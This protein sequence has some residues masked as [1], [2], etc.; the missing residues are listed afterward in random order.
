MQII[1][2]CARRPIW[3]S[4]KGSVFLADTHEH[5]HIRQLFLGS[6]QASKAPDHRLRLRRMEEWEFHF[7]H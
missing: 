7:G 6:A 3:Q 1:V 5:L 4:N 2:S